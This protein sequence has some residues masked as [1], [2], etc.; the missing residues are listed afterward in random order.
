MFDVGDDIVGMRSDVGDVIGLVDETSGVDQEAVASREVGELVAF[1]SGDSIRG[2]DT[3]LTVGQQTKRK[4][5]ALRER[6]V[7][8]GCVERCSENCHIEFGETIG[9]VTQSLSLD[10][11]TRCGGLGVP[12]QQHPMSLKIGEPNA[13]FVLIDQHERRRWLSWHQHG[14]SLPAESA[15]IHHGCSVCVEHWGRCAVMNNGPSDTACCV[16]SHTSR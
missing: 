7:L 3:V 1:I 12:P 8:S 4:L 13:S 14:S 5:L 6:K 2:A 16:T 10:S 15:R 9:P 11:S